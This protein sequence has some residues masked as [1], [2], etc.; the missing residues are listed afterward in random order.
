ML[1]FFSKVWFIGSLWC[2]T[3]LELLGYFHDMD[4]VDNP[5]E[6]R[7]RVRMESFMSGINGYD[8][9]DIPVIMYKAGIL[10]RMT[11]ALYNGMA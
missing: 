7:R 1:V 2:W 3:R 9:K 5:S 11:C 4:R 10:S 6:L 8:G